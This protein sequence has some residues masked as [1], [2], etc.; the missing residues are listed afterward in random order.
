[1]SGV[2]SKKVPWA[3]TASR[4]G[5]EGVADAGE[6]VDDALRFVVAVDPVENFLEARSVAGQE[7]A[8]I[9]PEGFQDEDGMRRGGVGEIGCVGWRS[10]GL[11]VQ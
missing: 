6:F 5:V 9:R 3:A 10:A 7:V 8:A 4:C 1:M 2:P 11:A